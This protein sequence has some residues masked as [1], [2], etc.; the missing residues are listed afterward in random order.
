MSYCKISSST[1]V[2]LALTACSGSGNDSM[3]ETP[4]TSSMITLDAR[5]RAAFG[6]DDD[7]SINYTVTNVSSQ[8]LIIFDAVSRATVGMGDDGVIILFK[9][10]RDTGFTN[11]ESRPTIAGRNLSPDQTLRGLARERFPTGIDFD[12]SSESIDLPDTVRLCLGFGNADD[13]I[14]TTLVDGTFPL[15]Q[16]LDLQSL[17]C[18]G[19]LEVDRSPIEIP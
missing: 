1:I 4:D 15:N 19:V 6:D 5:A 7:L 14:P 13:I 10:K 17:T 9:A 11:F 12:D 18:S 3:I 2:F 16:D 8:E